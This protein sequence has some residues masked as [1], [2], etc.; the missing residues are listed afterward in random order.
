MNPRLHALAVGMGVC[1]AVGAL[2]RICAALVR[3]DT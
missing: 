1:F 2:A 3:D